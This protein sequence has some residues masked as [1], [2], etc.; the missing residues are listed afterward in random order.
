MDALTSPWSWSTFAVAVGAA[1]LALIAIGVR[2]REPQAA[3]LLSLI[4]VA[5]S[6][7]FVFLRT[8]ATEI[9]VH[10]DLYVYQKDYVRAG[11]EGIQATVTS[12]PKDVGFALLMALA[13]SAGLQFVTFWAFLAAT[14]SLLLAVATRLVSDWPRAAL[15]LALLPL[16]FPFANGTTNILRQGLAAS[17]VGLVLIMSTQLTRW[18]RLG[19]LAVAATLL[20]WSALLPV[21]AIIGAKVMPRRRVVLFVWIVSA[22][23]FL[24]GLVGRFL[25]PVTVLF[26]PASTYVTNVGYAASGGPGSRLDFFA[27]TAFLVLAA[28]LLERRCKTSHTRLVT[29]FIAIAVTFNLFGFVA[30]G[31]R[32][33]V[34]TWLTFPIVAA[35]VTFPEAIDRLT[36]SRVKRDLLRRTAVRR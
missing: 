7:L 19:P 11:F 9:V 22:A 35:G 16:Y 18:R 27:F 33:A 23:M 36:S 20:H 25:G 3:G 1:A 26:E 8:Y 12:A 2:R 14:I 31:D 28:I 29:S 24:F 32:V 6:V 10:T 21:A 17:V 13:A 15:V 5:V 34:Y 30:F 4:S